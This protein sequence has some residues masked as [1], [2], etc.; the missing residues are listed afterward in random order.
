MAPPAPASVAAARERTGGAS[1]GGATDD[2]ATDGGATDGGATDGAAT[3]GGAT[4]GAATDGAATDGGA[5]DGA[6]TDGGAKEG[7][8][9]SNGDAA[10]AEKICGNPKD[11]DATCQASAVTKAADAL[12][13]Q[14]AF[15]VVAEALEAAGTVKR[16]NDDAKSIGSGTAARNVATCA[17]AETT[18]ASAA[19]TIE[20][21]NTQVKA[22]CDG[23]CSD[24]NT[25]CISATTGAPFCQGRHPY[26]GPPTQADPG[27]SIAVRVLGLSDIDPKSK[28]NVSS[29]VQHEP[30]QYF[31]P[32]PSGKQ[33]PAA[34]STEKPPPSFSERYEQ[35]LDVP[36][37]ASV[38]SLTITY[39]LTPPEGSEDKPVFRQYV[40]QVSH[41]H[42]YLEVGLLLAYVHGGKRKIQA[43]Q[44]PGTGGE[45]RVAIADDDLVAPAVA[46][47]FFP[48]G[49]R[50]GRI[51]A[52][53]PPRF[54]DLVGIEGGVDLDVTHALDRVYGGLALEPIAGLS[55]DLGIASVKADALPPGYVDGMLVPSGQSFSPG[56]KRIV[57]PYFGLTVTNRILTL[58]TT[59]ADSVR[60]TASGGK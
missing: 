27:S 54:W 25:L 1:D 53:N 34:R 14:P 40:L 58:I 43:A 48:G 29:N 18:R 38:T 15:T 4:D 46:V 49:R 6:A 13:K 8:A 12:D 51:A 60:T 19:K 55:L 21:W 56:S 52:L 2:A 9:A 57:R 5:T 7:G 50:I 36:T 31:N 26:P 23:R 17:D 3:D 20:D 45:R 16:M 24:P 11:C 42:Y 30:D 35:T 59:K 32:P 39:T 37:D 44:A 22:L 28:F 41:G 10:K 47:V 33:V